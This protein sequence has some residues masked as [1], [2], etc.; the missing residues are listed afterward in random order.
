MKRIVKGCLIMIT[1]L[2]AQANAQ[3]QLSLKQQADHLFERYEYLKSLNFYLKLA[4]RKKPNVGLLERVADCYRNIN[5]YS[6]AETWYARAVVDISASLLSHYNYAETLLYSQKFE[7][8]KQQ[9]QF[10]FAKVNEPEAMALKLATCDSATVWVKQTNGYI[11]KSAPN[12]NTAFSEWGVINDNNGGMIFT[13]DRRQASD[14]VD[15]RTGNNWFR[16]YLADAKGENSTE[17][18][19]VSGTSGLAINNHIGPMALTAKADT[20]YITI[21]T[22]VETKNIVLDKQNSKGAQKLY[23][24]R[25]QLVIAVKKYNQWIVVSGF[26]YNDINKYSL[27]HAALSKNGQLI[28][29]T[30][31]MSGGEGKTDI[32]YCEKLANGSWGK[33]V[34][35]GKN[36]NTKQ[37]EA[38]PEIGGDG[39]LYYSSKGLPGMGGYDIYVAKGE[40]ENWEIPVNLKYP[41]NTT[42]DDFCL[43]TKDGFTGYISSNR[44][45]GQGD[46]DIYQFSF[47]PPAKQI[48]LKDAPKLAVVPNPTKSREVF[49]ANNIYYDLDK[50]NI[51]PD[52]AVE[53]DKLVGLLKA[54]PLFKVSV[55]SHTDS[56]APGD[57]NLTL[58]QRRSA[59]AIAYLVKKGISAQRLISSYYGKTQ[60]LNECTDGVKCT[61]EQQQLNRRTEF[62]LI[63]D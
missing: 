1:L 51:R 13:T 39:V 50:F 18:Y 49:M 22:D 27:G 56:R 3:E 45:G 52:A 5:R 31:D 9:Y 4:N 48:I 15:N 33:P 62:R 12:L 19:V 61:E 60:L 53:L 46:D 55:A 58:S 32:W 42:A 30:S 25:L 6:E 26:P 43:V 37:E 17:I 59:S 8:A 10:Y 14:P 63:E 54:H 23:T 41:I 11:V 16:L 40:K 38:F 21:T 34:N 44:L 24:R 2:A 20:A 36:I 47:K 7:Q 35:C 57:Y 28:Y 29:F